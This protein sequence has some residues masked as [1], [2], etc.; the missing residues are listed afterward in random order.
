MLEEVQSDQVLD[1]EQPQ[2]IEVTLEEFDKLVEFKKALD[3]LTSSDE[4]KLVIEQSFI[5]EDSE[6]LLGLLM[7]NNRQ[8]IKDRDIINQKIYGKGY[9]KQ[10]ITEQSVSLEGIDNPANRA[11]LVK[12]LAELEQGA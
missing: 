4:Y 6:R 10:W 2:A 12:Q 11:E 3:K 8:V 5:K 9:F 7:S 1:N